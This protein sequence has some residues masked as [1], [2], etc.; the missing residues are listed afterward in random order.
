MPNTTEDWTKIQKGYENLW[1]FPNCCGQQGTTTTKEHIA[2]SCLQW[3]M[4]ITVLRTLMLAV[5]DVQVTV[6][7]S[8]IPN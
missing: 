6:L 3:L 7:Y 4:Q 2:L 8:E 5:T 1:N